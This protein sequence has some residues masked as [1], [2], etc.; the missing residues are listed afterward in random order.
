[1]KKLI[2]L[3]LAVLML[4]TPALAEPVVRN[5]TAFPFGAAEF[6][7][8]LTLM[9]TAASSGYEAMEDAPGLFRFDG[10]PYPAEIVVTPTENA[11]SVC[12]T[13]TFPGLDE[14]GAQFG[15]L[16]ACCAMT[17]LHA[18]GAMTPERAER[19][20]D[21]LARLIEPLGDCT[22]AELLAGVECVGDVGGFPAYLC[23]TCA[24]S[25]VCTLILYP[26]GTD[27]VLE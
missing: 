6:G 14:G 2:S 18:S 5:T 7:A 9:L 20:G 11:A 3:L 22:N 27:L 25:M 17:V 16:T 24:D 19:V 1:M 26:V 10:T 15:Y 12:L 8:S 21:D 23:V 13:Q 4:C